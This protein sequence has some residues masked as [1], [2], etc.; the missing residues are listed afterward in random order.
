MKAMIVAAGLGTRLKPITDSIPK[1]LVP[2]GSKPLLEHVIHKLIEGGITELVINVHHFPE[3][4]TKF[5]ADNHSFGI[6]IHFSDETVELLET[7]GG[8]RKARK[9]LGDEPFLVHN[10]DILSNLNLTALI[11]QHQRTQPLA[12]LVVSERDTFR[13]FLFDD[14]N[15]LRGWNNLKTGQVKPEQLRHPELYRKL[16]F[17][18]IQILSPEI[19]NLMEDWPERF[20][21]TDFYLQHV[22][23]S[24]ILGYT[25]ENYRMMD[26]GKLDVLKEAE[27]WL[28]VND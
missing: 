23:T 13:Y 16:A 8:I 22:N 1:A 28:M 26:V 24:T 7:G 27:E 11:A 21:I 10:V 9:W 17:S 20:S 5:I 2:V 25:Q 19:F 14:D 4:I 3:Q 18:G 12:T 15:R 6:P